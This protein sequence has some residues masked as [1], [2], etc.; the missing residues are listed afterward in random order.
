MNM[1]THVHATTVDTVLLVHIVHAKLV[2]FLQGAVKNPG[3]LQRTHR[4][5]QRYHGSMGFLK[6]LGFYDGFYDGR[7]VERLQCISALLNW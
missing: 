2:G 6:E 1:V 7:Y 4:F 3:V 5:C